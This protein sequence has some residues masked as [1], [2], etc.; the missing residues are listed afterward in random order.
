MLLCLAVF[1]PN[2]ASCQ[3]TKPQKT[4][5]QSSQRSQIMAQATQQTPAVNNRRFADDSDGERANVNEKTAKNMKMR[6][7]EPLETEEFSLGASVSSQ[8]V[9][10]NGSSLPQNQA[11]IATSAHLESTERPTLAPPSERLGEQLQ[12]K[13]DEA[14]PQ[15][16]PLQPAVTGHRL[17]ARQKQMQ[18]GSDAPQPISSSPASTSMIIPLASPFSSDSHQQQ[19]QQHSIMKPLFV[20]GQ[21]LSEKDYSSARYDAT[22]AVTSEDLSTRATLTTSQPLLSEPQQPLQQPHQQQQPQQQ[23]QQ[24]LAMS[25][26]VDGQKG[27]EENAPSQTNP[28]P[29]AQHADDRMSGPPLIY[30]AGNLAPVSE[31]PQAGA[32]AVQNGSVAQQAA[33]ARFFQSNQGAIFPNSPRKPSLP[34]P[35][36]QA[37]AAS[38]FRSPL[39]PS[40]PLVGA[41]SVALGMPANQVGATNYYPAAPYAGHSSA[42]APP[43][44]FAASAGKQPQLSQQSGQP[45]GQATTT[46]AYLT[47]RPLNITRVE[48]K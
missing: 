30:S 41:P 40:G 47:R 38:G 13:S 48:R 8:P 26:S 37:N 16:V 27:G 36:S 5:R 43:N 10:A 20:I 15:I 33:A 39:S 14:P 45:V 9:Q 12:N 29:P 23:I 11:T 17:G 42:P 46:S 4:A 44:L 24:R 19:Q 25:K 22:A 35:V 28:P 18:F 3:Q 31:A 2:F 1:V 6:A 34:P 7:P 21:P 32:P